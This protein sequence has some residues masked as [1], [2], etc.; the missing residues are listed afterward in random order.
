MFRR[1]L[2]RFPPIFFLQNGVSL[3]F[4]AGNLHPCQKSPSTQTATLQEGK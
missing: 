2:A 3:C 4:R 1:S